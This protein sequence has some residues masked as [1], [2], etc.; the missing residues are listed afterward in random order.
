MEWRKAM[1]KLY[2]CCMWLARC[3]QI[4]AHTI[5]DSHNANRLLQQLCT[6]PSTRAIHHTMSNS[7]FVLHTGDGKKFKRI[8]YATVQ[9]LMLGQWLPKHVAVNSLNFNVILI[10]LWAFGGLHSGKWTIL[11][12][13]EKVYFLCASTNVS[14]TSGLSL[15]SNVVSSMTGP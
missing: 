10:I 6:I 14:V 13:M 12:G 15:Y 7:H 3:T 4:I 8:F 1:Y 5:S 2:I 11:Q 9:C